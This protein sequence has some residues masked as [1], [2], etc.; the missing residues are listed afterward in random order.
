M[1]TLSRGLSLLA[2]VAW[3]GLMLYFYYS[4]RLNSYLIPSYRPLV[5]V[6]GFVMLGIAA[7]LAY[8]LSQ[9]AR[10]QMAGGLIADDAADELA[11]PGRVRTMQCLAFG[12]LVLPIWSATGVSKDGFSASAVRNRGIVEDASRLPGR[13]SAALVASTAPAAATASAVYEPPLPGATP[14]PADAASGAGANAAVDAS[15]YMKTTPDGHVLAEVTDLLFSAEDD[16]M[17]PAFEG[18]TV[19]VIGQYLPVKDSAS[20]RFQIVR[21]FMVCC[22]ADARPVAVISE[23]VPA[24]SGEP[25]VAEMGW[26]RV[27]GKVTFPVEDGRRLPIIKAEKLTPCDPPAEA[28]LY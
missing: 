22:A 27:T 14:I 4:G 8:T 20:G 6:S 19:E 9:G 17:R 5:A 25:K 13:P 28:M 1:K 15:Q 10:W 12:L 3:G 23:K 16:T 2:L 7:S 11:S 24:V 26:A 18:R 21:M